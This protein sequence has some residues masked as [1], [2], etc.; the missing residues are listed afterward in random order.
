MPPA[1]D[2]L[3][4][5]VHW[6]D[7]PSLV[8]SIRTRSLVARPKTAGECRE[9]RAWCREHG[10][11]LCPR[12]SGRSYG[13][14]ALNDR[15]VLLDVGRMNR[16]LAFD[17]EAREIRVEA[18]TRLIDI[19][20]RVHHKGLTLGASPTESHSSVSG[21]LSANV[22]G[23]DAWRLGS[24][25]DQVVRLSLM[26]A[27]G[28]VHEVDRSHEFFDGVVGGLGLLG[29][30]L[31]ATLRLEPIPSPYVETTVLPARNVDELLEKMA[32]VEQTSDFAVA[33]V[34][35]YA[36]GA[37][38]GRSVIHA[39][40]WTEVKQTEE[41]RKAAIDAGIERLDKHR[42]F[43]LALHAAFGPLLS[44]MLQFQRPFLRFF[45]WLYYTKSRMAAGGKHVELFLQYS[46]AASFTVP[47]AYLVCG[48][49]GYTVQVTFP[50]ASAREALVELLEICQSSPCPPV[51]TIL[52]AHRADD[53]WISFSEDGYSLNFEIHPKKRHV[54]KSREV[55]DR[56]VDAVAR[57]GGKVHLAKDQ[58][59]TP[60]PFRRLYPKHAQL[61]ALKARLDPDGLFATDLAR[62][63]GLCPAPGRTEGS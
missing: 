2:P 10:L 22:N 51:T 63:V 9:V 38:L 48:P 53:R 44:L 17:E 20:A 1:P 50:R 40:R 59:L 42:R 62:R 4:S 60:E 52:R 41:E 30:V 28:E 45:N 39:S 29:I 19:F 58:V 31:D 21:A 8:G 27:D 25:G 5:F 56:L 26:T 57:R 18:G 13:D 12:G 23:K 55:V 32:E 54:A 36:R 24:F 33:W 16:I 14:M 6:E 34:N 47:P 49:R 43:G 7:V 15:Q 3:P 46:F 35:V 37:K 11:T 61:L